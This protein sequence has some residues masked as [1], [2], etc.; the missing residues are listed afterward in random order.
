MWREIE[1]NTIPHPHPPQGGLQRG[2]YRTCEMMR[3][4]VQLGQEETG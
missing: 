2:K 1:Q 3:S 4:L